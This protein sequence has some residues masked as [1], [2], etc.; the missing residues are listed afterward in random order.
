MQHPFRT[1]RDGRPPLRVG[2]ILAKPTFCSARLAAR[3]SFL[4]A[5]T[6]HMSIAIGESQRDVCA[7]P[8]FR[9]RAVC[10]SADIGTGCLLRS[11][12][13]GQRP[14]SAGMATSQEMVNEWPHPAS[15]VPLFPSRGVVRPDRTP[16]LAGKAAT[17]NLVSRACTA[18]AGGSGGGLFE[19][20]PGEGGRQVTSVWRPGFA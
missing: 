19:D 15:L 2:S 18:G 4:V 13:A 17:S 14:D 8:Y 3:F 12:S 1:A 10:P 20:G 6:L 16:Y 7:R 11:S 5:R 9:G